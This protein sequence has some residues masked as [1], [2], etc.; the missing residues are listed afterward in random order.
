MR[1]V[2][3]LSV[4]V[5]VALPGCTVDP[6]APLIPLPQRPATVLPS[7][8]PQQTADGYPNI[9]ADPASVPGLPRDPRTVEEGKRQVAAEGAASKARTAAIDRASFA[10]DLQAR[11]ASQREAT[12][13]RIEA[14]SNA[15]GGS[16][17]PSN[18][19][20]VRNRIASGGQRAPRETDPAGARTEPS[21]APQALPGAPL[22]PNAA[23]PRTVGPEPF[24]GAPVAPPQ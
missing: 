9:L 10:G 17:A 2:W 1:A 24:S 19:E 8:A 5:A 13:R 6:A 16:A 22:D 18:P 15:G 4:V 12:R 11:A 20:D 3:R 7:E 23:P 14:S 21:A